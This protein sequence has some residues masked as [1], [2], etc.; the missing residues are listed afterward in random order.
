MRTTFLINSFQE[1]NSKH[2][3]TSIIIFLLCIFYSFGS[4]A[5]TNDFE[6]CSENYEAILCDP[7]VIDTLSQSYNLALSIPDTLGIDPEWEFG[8]AVL[9]DNNFFYFQWIKWELE[10]GTFSFYQFYDCENLDIVGVCIVGSPEIDDGCYNIDLM[11][12]VYT[13]SDFNLITIAD[14]N[15]YSECLN[16]ESFD[17]LCNPCGGYDCVD[18]L[19][20]NTNIQCPQN[21]NPVCGCDGKTYTNS[22]IA[23]NYY[24]VV[25]WTFGV[26]NTSDCIDAEQI[27]EDIICPSIYEPVCGCDGKTYNNSCIA[28]NYFGIIDW[29]DGVCPISE[30]IDTALINDLPCPDLYE[31]ICGCDGITYPN[32]CYAVNSGVISWSIGSCD[33]DNDCFDPDLVDEDIVCPQVYD[34]VCGCDGITYANACFAQ[35]AGVINFQI[36]E[37]NSLECDSFEFAPLP[38][39]APPNSSIA[40][41]A[42]SQYGEDFVCGCDGVTYQ[43]ACFAYYNG[44]EYYEDG[45]CGTQ[46][47][48]GPIIDIQCPQVY[49]PVCGCDGFTY[50]NDC[51]AL[52]SGIQSWILGECDQICVLPANITYNTT[53]ITQ[54]SARLNV[55][56]GLASAT[57]IWEHRKLGDPLWSFPIETS[58]PFR[59]IFQLS[60]CTT[61]EWKVEIICENDISAGFNIPITFETICPCI[62]LDQIDENIQCPQNYEPV[63]GCDGKTYFNSCI[64]ENYHGVTEWALGPCSISDCKDETQVNTNIQCPQVYDPVCGC[65]GKTYNNFCVAEFY[66]GITDWTNGA[67][68]ESECIDTS[69]INDL[70]CPL[71][72]F[73]V[74]G[75]DG[76]TYPNECYAIGSGVI[77]WT[78][79]PCSDDD[80][81]IDPDLIEE[82]TYCPLDYNPVCGCDGVTYPNACSAQVAGVTSYIMGHCNSLA[83]DSFEFAPLPI[84]GAPDSQIAIDSCSQFENNPVCGCDDITYQNSCFAYYNGVE[85]Y[86]NGACGTQPCMG[87]ILDIDCPLVFEP[88]CGCDEMTYF[89]D[90]EAVRAG[91]QEW[92]SGECNP[93]CNLP[94]NISY[95]TT[96]ITE[97]SARLNIINGPANATYIWY[98]AEINSALSFIGTSTNPIRNISQ[99]MGCTTYKWRVEIICENGISAGFS[100]TI[101]FSTF[102]EDEC[103]LPSSIEFDV[104]NITENSATFIVING[105][106][107][108]TYRWQYTSDDISGWS[109]LGQS[110]NPMINVSQLEECTTYEWRV[111]II[112]ENGVSA[113]F[114][115]PV[116]FSTVCPCINLE[117]IDENIQCTQDYVPVCGCDGKT[118]TNSCIA[119]NY[120]GLTGWTVGTCNTSECIDESL[121]DQN[122]NC[123]SNYEPVC[124]CNGKTYN[125]ACIAENYFGIIE[126]TLGSC[127]GSDCIDISL[128]SDLPCPEVYAPVCGCDGVTYPNECYAVNSGVIY[129]NNGPCAGDECIDLN[130]IDENIVCPEFYEPVCGCNDVTYTNECFAKSA[131]IINYQIG[132]CNGLSCDGFEFAPLPVI[133]APD[134]P[135][136]MN[137]CNQYGENPVC[138]CDGIT[139]QNGCFAYYNGVEYYEAGACGTQLCTGPTFDN[140]CP[141]VIEY[142]C[143]CDGITYNNDCEALNAGIQE[144]TK[145]ECLNISCELDQEPFVDIRNSTESS[146]DV[147]IENVE[148]GLIYIVQYRPINE[149]LVQSYL[150]TQTTSTISNLME[151]TTYECIVEVYCENEILGYAS[152]PITF[153]TKCADCGYNSEVEFVTT[154][155]TFTSANLNIE[156]L[157]ADYETLVWLLKPKGSI[158]WSTIGS[159]ELP[160][161]SANSLLECNDYQWTVEIYCTN[162]EFGGSSDVV[163]FKTECTNSTNENDTPTVLVFPTPSNSIIQMISDVPFQ[164]FELFDISGTLV[165][166][167]KLSASSLSES[168]DVQDYLSGIY[169]VKIYISDKEFVLRRIAVY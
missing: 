126:W 154:D 78:E 100:E 58:S 6:N 1:L 79:G 45:A 115:V 5:Q 82:N 73:P 167:K 65:D 117:L 88:V 91:I 86:E 159:G 8:F 89:N 111:E 12:W 127:P 43:N 28:V 15:S 95:L 151:C 133:A 46:P 97:T 33:L 84:I 77:S 14:L 106:P 83:C 25:E 121:I 94:T 108:A 114:S 158:E 17:D 2:M 4:N 64:A 87:P 103:I 128:I 41:D 143:G 141:T 101:E 67:C 129:W 142:V 139:Y 27:D 13:L 23:E 62:D 66:Y 53:N 11:N 93:S 155:I 48:M 112:C 123:P 150:T 120:F 149:S 145:G 44:V 163:E 34:P 168:L 51:F 30:C 161:I 105:P 32:E 130:L 24:G 9:E 21:Y 49:D 166:S 147:V 110:N 42:C 54:V 124:G 132:E 38:I 160:N 40:I 61:Y 55:N 102:C 10:N 7:I 26:C 70:P 165:D 69:L 148:E 116:S 156:M 122:V 118:Y 60:S 71:L 85:Y 131:G 19:Q 20:I 138:G 134:T 52:Q 137:A 39:I 80:E 22:C 104:I 119:Q 113:G 37:C 92:T 57:Y 169:I 99:L 109:F 18:T 125:N 36:G 59:N 81:C 29:T 63:C 68:E 31:P 76:L 72:Y 164:R 50:A 35:S 162:F 107:S 153:K 47:C 136:A 152:A 146:V 56:N 98:F 140:D 90:C 16:P 75:C 135:T 144:W 96:N 3:K 157:D 74:C